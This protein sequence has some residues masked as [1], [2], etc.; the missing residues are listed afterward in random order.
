MKVLLLSPLPPPS[1]GIARWTERYLTWCDGKISVDL[2]NTAL[3]GD[4]AGEA[5][6]QKKLFDEINRSLRI[7]RETRGK[8]KGEPDLLHL[9]TSCSKVGII[10]DWFCIRV[11]KKA[12]IPYIVHC[13]CNIKDQLGNGRIANKL[14]ISII[15]GAAKVLVLNQKSS[16]FVSHIAGDKTIICPN[17]VL[18]EQ[19]ADSHRVRGSLEKLIYVG[20]VRFSKGSDDIYKLAEKCPDK[21]FIIVG[22][23]TDEIKKLKKPENVQLLGRLEADGV[24]RELDDADVFLFPS[25]SEGF[26]NALLEAMARGLP[27]IATDVGANADMIK[28]LGGRIAE[29]HDIN[30]MYTAIEEMEPA[31]IREKMSSW[32]TN[33]TRDKYEYNVVMNQIMDIYNSIC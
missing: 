33:V 6:V 25:L 3:I 1:G 8:L 29:I 28:E 11:A 21:H 15:N 14:F 17:F 30:G 10:R 5:G 22:S 24:C 31:S 2:V 12:R 32:N 26:S 13:H 19:I 18:T 23:V 4:R 27:V 20:D 7:I 9:N 16:E